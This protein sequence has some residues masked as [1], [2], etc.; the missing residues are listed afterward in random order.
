[1]AG[2]FLVAGVLTAHSEALEPRPWVLPVGFEGGLQVVGSG[3]QA[4]VGHGI[5]SASPGRGAR[6]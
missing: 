2:G 4:V 3:G 5:E 1:M 6:K